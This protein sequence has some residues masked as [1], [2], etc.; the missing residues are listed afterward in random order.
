MTIIDISTLKRLLEAASIMK[1]PAKYALDICEFLIRQSPNQMGYV[2][3]IQQNILSG[4]ISNAIG[5]CNNIIFEQ[6][7]T[8]PEKW[9]FDSEMLN[10]IIS[11]F[12]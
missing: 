8:I 7:N 6:T 12:K 2:M 4:N 3:G 9:S 5:I 10:E 11:K 1:I